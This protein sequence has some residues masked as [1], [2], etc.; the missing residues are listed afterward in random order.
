M[1][2][3]RFFK[4]FLSDGRGVAKRAAEDVGPYGEAYK[5]ANPVGNAV[6]GVPW[7]DGNRGR[8]AEDGV[9]YEMVWG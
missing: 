2:R 6:P 8:N 9:P 5:D 1:D 7:C 3:P 4:L